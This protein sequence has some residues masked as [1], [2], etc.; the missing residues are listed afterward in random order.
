MN[1]SI[2]ARLQISLIIL[3]FLCRQTSAQE[4]KFSLDQALAHDI[5]KELIEINTTHSRGDCTLAAEAMAKRF[6]DAG[7]EEK[8]I[9]V[10]GPTAVNKNI[11][12]RLHG[13]GKKPAILFLAHL[14]VVEAKREDWSYDPF[15]LTEYNG[16]F[17]GREHWMLKRG[18]GPG[19]Q[20]YPFEARR[21]CAGSGPDTGNDGG[22]ES[23]VDYCGVEWLLANHRPLIDAVYCINGM[24]EPQRKVEKGFFARCR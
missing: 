6:K 3:L 8:D 14:D 7:F 4:L 18:C 21:L 24:G 22:E 9:V 5:Y 15:K 1:K 13:S 19:Y 23:A 16:Y 17:Y 20:F 2:K 10:I 11:I 12:V